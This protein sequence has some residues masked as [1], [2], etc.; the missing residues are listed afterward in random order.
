MVVNF[1][2]SNFFT[3]NIYENAYKF[4]GTF[5]GLS[6][7]ASHHF[8]DPWEDPYKF[9]PERFTKEKDDA[10]GQ[11]FPFGGGKR[12]CIGMNFSYAEQR[13]FLAMFGIYIFLEIFGEANF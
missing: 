7:Y 1:L 5:V 2:Y 4:V 12:I 8:N 6:I 3:L 11:S 9:K 10:T 13:V